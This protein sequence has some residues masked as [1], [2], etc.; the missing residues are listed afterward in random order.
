MKKFLREA[1]EVASSSDV[2]VEVLEKL[3]THSFWQVRYAVA[4]NP[5]I[6]IS[7]IKVLYNDVEWKVR[8]A[9]MKRSNLPVSL[10]KLLVES[11]DV[12]SRCMVARYQKLSL[13][14]QVVLSVDVSYGVRRDLVNNP[15]LDL[16][17]VSVLVKDADV[18]VREVVYK[19]FGFLNVVQEALRVEKSFIVRRDALSNE[20]ISV[21][22]LVTVMESFTWKEREKLELL[23][24]DNVRRAIK[25][26]S[27][28]H[29]PELF[30]L[31][32][33]YIF[34]FYVLFADE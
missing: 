17:I 24:I 31:P 22:V 7:L 3:S 9:V 5:I 1:I 27:E 28:V 30:P 29:C 15:F 4:S 8:C 25:G 21:E 14:Q 13:R 18:R 16:S 10:I 33:S 34:Q 11:Y 32:A 12:F 26:W 19:R 23:H 2:S 6:P 20:E